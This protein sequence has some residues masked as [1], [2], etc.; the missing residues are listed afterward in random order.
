MLLCSDGRVPIK[1]IRGVLTRSKSS[2]G[3]DSVKGGRL[4]SLMNE[5]S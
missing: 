3:E 5:C 1:D 4:S 2:F